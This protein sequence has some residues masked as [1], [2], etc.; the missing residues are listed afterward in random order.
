MR[1][2]QKEIA[3]SKEVREYL[4]WDDIQKMKHTWDVVSE[5]LRLTSPITGSFREALVDLNYQGYIIPKGWK[6]YWNGAV[7]HM[8]PKFFPNT[9]KFD[10]SRFEGAG[11]TP[12]SYVPFGGGPRM[13]L[14]K[15]FARLE[16]LVFIHNV[17][18]DFRWKLL[19][20]NE[21]IEYDPM[22]TPIEGLPVLLQPHSS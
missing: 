6:L 2:E 4:N 3:T 10:P 15:E 9:K 11:P 18:K 20:P 22:P 7:T 21:K 13:C 14:G 17:V 12:F 1:T 8:D 19:I 5:V 16:I